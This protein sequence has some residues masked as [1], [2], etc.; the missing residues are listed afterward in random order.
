LQQRPAASRARFLLGNTYLEAGRF[1]E[2]AAQ[3][4]EVATQRPDWAGLHG[5]L[6]YAYLLS[7]R[8]LLAVE[9]YRRAL[10]L[11]PDSTVV[12]YQLARL[13]NEMDSLDAAADQYKSLLAAEPENALLHTLL[14]N[15]LI[16]DPMRDIGVGANEHIER[17]EGHLRRALELA[18]NGT[19]AR[20]SLAMLR[21]RQGRYHESTLIFEELL[22][23]DSGDGLLHFCLANLYRRTGQLQ[24][25]EMSMDRYS[26]AVR[27]KR[28]RHRAEAE[29]RDVIESMG[30]VGKAGG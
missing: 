3:Y 9:S 22:Q 29:I 4:E 7:H 13:Y 10:E 11:R 25:A 26:S 6:G 18:P 2:A 23:L 1:E 21:A 16:G 5:R 20:W 15:A 28:V 14:A 17:A 8:P 30:I 27:D 12:R 19:Q 24:R